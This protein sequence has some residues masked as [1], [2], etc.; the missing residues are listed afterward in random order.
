MSRGAD[1]KCFNHT[2]FHVGAC[3][4]REHKLI[5]LMIDPWASSGLTTNGINM[6]SV[7][8]EPVER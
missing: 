6:L 4:G 8:P 5:R 7:L 1:G 3:D 2:G